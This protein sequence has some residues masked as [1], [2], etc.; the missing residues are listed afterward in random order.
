MRVGTQNGSVSGHPNFEM[1]EIGAN[2]LIRHGWLV[3]LTTAIFD[4]SPRRRDL[5]FTVVSNESNRM[6]R[7]R[8]R[9]GRGNIAARRRVGVS[10]GTTSSRIAN[11][12]A[13]VSHGGTPRNR[14]RISAHPIAVRRRRSNGYSHVAP[15]NL[16]PNDGEARIPAAQSR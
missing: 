7:T 5:T 4:N 14:S 3:D 1:G 11:L 16:P 10:S 8:S 6:G 15:A 13:N 12:S 2:F 9:I